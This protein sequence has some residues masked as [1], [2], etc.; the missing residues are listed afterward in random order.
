MKIAMISM[1]IINL[2]LDERK[3]NSLINGILIY[4]VVFV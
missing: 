4:F 3:F 1:S 2:L